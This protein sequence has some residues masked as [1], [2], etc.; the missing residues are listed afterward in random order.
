[1]LSVLL[2]GGRPGLGS[3]ALTPRYIGWMAALKVSRAG[4]G[5]GSGGGSR[6]AAPPER[7]RARNW[8]GSGGFWECSAAKPRLAMKKLA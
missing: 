7:K 5:R 8:S 3:L 2:F 1:M 6:L 4:D